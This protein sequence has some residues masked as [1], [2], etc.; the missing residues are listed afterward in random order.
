MLKQSNH[1]DVKK[2]LISDLPIEE[3]E[4]IENLVDPYQEKKPHKGFHIS[5]AKQGHGS[6]KR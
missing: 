6:K 4:R 1:G 2:F 3:Q 5:E